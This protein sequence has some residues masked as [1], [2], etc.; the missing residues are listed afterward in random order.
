MGHATRGSG[1]GTTVPV[2]LLLILSLLLCVA[3]SPAEAARWDPRYRWHTLDTPHFSIHFHQGEAEVAAEM[4]IV[5]EEVHALLAPKL[6]WK[7][8]GR[9]QVVLVDPTDAPN[10]YASTV[11]YNAIVLYL[12]PP[13]SQSSL[14]NYEHWLWALF[15]HEYTHV[16]QI[17]M[18]GGIPQV[19]RWIFGRLIVPGA[20]LPSWLTEGYA[21]YIETTLTAGGRGRSTMTDAVLRT[22]ALDGVLPRVDQADG[23]GQRWPR[24]QVRYL[25]GARF[26]LHVAQK[27]S[28][29]AW[30][31][32]YQR[33]ARGIIP[34]LLPAKK[35]FGATLA[36]L[37]K[38]WRSELSDRYLD[39]AERIAAEG[40]GVTPT[41]VLPSREG[42]SKYPLY[43]PD[44]QSVFYVHSSARE[45]SSL[46]KLHRDGSRDSRIRKGA[47]ADPT[48]SADGRYLYGAA[49]GSTNR[50][51][52]YRD[53]YRYDVETGKRKRLTRGARLT[54]PTAHPSGDWLVA[55]KTHR[56]QTQL[57]R[58]ELSASDVVEDEPESVPSQ[59][60]ARETQ[61]T[62]GTEAEEVVLGH[63]EGA[64]IS[65][66][67]A[68]RDGSQ[69]SSPRFDPQGHRLAVSIWKPG[70]FRDIHVLDT[71]GQQLRVLSWDRASDADPA[72]SPD[73]QWLLW[74]SDRDGVWNLYAYRWADGA[75]FRVTRV[76]GGARNPHI[77]PNGKHILF[78]SYTSSGWRL[79]EM[80]FDP[81][82]W[83][84]T[85][86]AARSLPGP[87]YGPS[88]Q[89][90]SPLS[91]V[92]GLPGPAA[93]YGEGAAAAV[94]RAQ[95]RDGYRTL[96]PRAAE[97]SEAVAVEAAPQEANTGKVKKTKRKRDLTDPGPRED[98]TQDIPAKLGKLARY[99]PLRTLFPPRYLALYGA[100]T[101]TG[102]LGGVTTGGADVLSQH[103][104]AAS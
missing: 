37:W 32:F 31:D 23:F 10:G 36:Q 34:L 85:A 14:A 54:Q 26:H 27:T 7:P 12:T 101:D 3:S 17:D 88:A 66:I 61:V 42:V 62:Q 55:V 16:L 39:E 77:A 73:G 89:A 50:Y 63:E 78:Q 60:D 94:K 75:V 57:V 47:V 64:L 28:D 46:R 11:P 82:R 19:L 51:V 104:W 81:K 59:D 93:P 49:V 76:I 79:E 9:T 92:E 100:A 68:A 67:T 18:V 40:S 70:G 33:H 6:Q 1:I 65:A 53:L 86:L 43:S 48:W 74:S 52:S 71:Q 58:V 97:G 44:G 35:A 72:W 84:P 91:A 30:V 98:P 41:R 87:G 56:S 29:A 102:W 2:A 22:A 96:A 80:P 45:R 25:Y 21:T 99:N 8:F 90:M 95:Q 13:D 15:V 5:A 20:V 38:E 83:E 103:A 69:F 4:A 24:G